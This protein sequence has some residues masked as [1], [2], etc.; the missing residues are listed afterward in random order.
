MSKQ[1]FKTDAR[2][3]TRKVILEAGTKS[4]LKKGY[5][6]C[7]L[8][9]ILE[10]A[11]VPK[12]SFYYYF[13]SK[14]DFGLALIENWLEKYAEAE[15]WLHDGSVSPLTRVRRFFEERYRM[16]Q[17]ARR[18]YGCMVGTLF[19]EMAAH[20]ETF[21]RRVQEILTAWL[22]QIAECLVQAQRAAEIGA[23]LDARAMAEFCL[24]SWEGAVQRGKTVQS[25]APL[26]LF[27]QVIFDS[28]LTK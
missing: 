2:A 28:L 21:R 26:D 3:D 13:P 22:D 10:E 4:I 14:E 20:N 18:Q 9:E 1:S 24:I 8:A 25:I 7:G 6:Q 16:F 19:A 27:F 12:G 17:R 15:Q 11:G 23:D 5:H